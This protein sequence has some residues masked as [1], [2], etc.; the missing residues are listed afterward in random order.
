MYMNEWEFKKPK[1][2]FVEWKCVEKK[3]HENKY[4]NLVK[5]TTYDSYKK[6]RVGGS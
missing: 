6:R 5:I 4:K 1:K 2:T 3:K